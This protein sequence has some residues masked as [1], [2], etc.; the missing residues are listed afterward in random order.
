[1]MDITPQGISAPVKVANE[2]YSLF[3]HQLLYLKLD[4]LKELTL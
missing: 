3:L 2:L 1:M 4:E